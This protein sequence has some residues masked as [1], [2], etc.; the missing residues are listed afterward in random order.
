MSR[1]ADTALGDDEPIPAVLAVSVGL[2][3][4]AVDLLRQEWARGV[5]PV[6]ARERALRA[7]AECGQ[8][9]EE[10]V[11]FSGGVIV[12]QVRTAATDILRASGVDY[13]EAPRLVRRA[14]GRPHSGRRRTT[15]RTG[16]S[17][18]PA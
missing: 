9:Y 1:R 17:H 8:A 15:S 6:A 4:D 7:A 16:L 3:G 5:E 18:P 14:V 13:A 12:A 10:G 2:L 11:G